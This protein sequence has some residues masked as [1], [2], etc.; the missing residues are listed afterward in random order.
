MRGGPCN[1]VLL[2]TLIMHGFLYYLIFAPR[3]LVE[4]LSLNAKAKIPWWRRELETEQSKSYLL[5]IKFGLIWEKRTNKVFP[6]QSTFEMYR[7]PFEGFLQAQRAY[8]APY[9]L[10]KKLNLSTK[11]IAPE[12]STAYSNS[13]DL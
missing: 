7:K 13:F 2:F 9:F 8:F 5:G 6:N 3:S 10:M 12:S 11:R 4:S 1:Q